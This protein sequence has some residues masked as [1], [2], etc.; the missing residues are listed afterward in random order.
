[1]KTLK[2]ADTYAPKLMTKGKGAD[3]RGLAIYK[4][5]KDGIKIKLG[6]FKKTIV[7]HLL[8]PS[9]VFFLDKFGR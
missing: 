7:S 6:N 2:N 8:R 3:L 5:K 9:N 4:E 1:M